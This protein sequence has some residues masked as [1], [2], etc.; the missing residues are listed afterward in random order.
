MTVVMSTDRLTDDVG[1]RRAAASPLAEP[2]SRRP[3]LGFLA[4]WLALAAILW[5]LP[6][7]LYDALFARAPRKPR[8]A[9]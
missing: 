3:L 9:D 7:P 1:R 8:R 5:L 2:A 6:R 4:A